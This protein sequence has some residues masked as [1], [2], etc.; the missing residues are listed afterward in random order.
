MEEEE[1]GFGNGALSVTMGLDT[2]ETVLRNVTKIATY[3]EAVSNKQQCRDAAASSWMHPSVNWQALSV[4][5][6][7]IWIGPSHLAI[8]SL[9]VERQR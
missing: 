6:A 4:C 9:P 2:R 7:V 1:G 8:A 3:L 5:V